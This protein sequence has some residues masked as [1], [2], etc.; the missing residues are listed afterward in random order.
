MAGDEQA[1]SNNLTPWLVTVNGK[2][3]P[4]TRATVVGD[5]TGERRS[6]FHKEVGR[7]TLCLGCFW[8]WKL[9]FL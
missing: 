5:W 2:G 4:V 1:A 9:C 7:S 8:I 6:P 3:L